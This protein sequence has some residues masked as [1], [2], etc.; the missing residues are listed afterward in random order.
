MIAALQSKYAIKNPGT[1]LTSST[2]TMSRF[3]S[4][5]AIPILRLL[6]ANQDFKK[7]V[8][9]EVLEEAGITIP[10]ALQTPIAASVFPRNLSMSEAMLKG[11]LKY[12]VKFDKVIHDKGKRTPLEQIKSFQR[13]A[14]NSPLYSE[15]VRRGFF[16]EM[17]FLIEEGGVISCDWIEE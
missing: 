1:K 6:D 8:P 9:E 2:I 14:Y 3:A 15:N 5:Y 4:V 16:V 13:A 10:R 17:G 11:H 7:Y 12:L